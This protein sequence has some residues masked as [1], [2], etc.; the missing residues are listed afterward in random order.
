MLFLIEVIKG[1]LMFAAVC[2]GL[3]IVYLVF[4]IAREVG[5]VVKQESRKQYRAKQKQCGF[6]GTAGSYI[7]VIMPGGCFE[8]GLY[9]RVSGAYLQIY[10]GEYPG[11]IDNIEINFCPK[12]GRMLMEVEDGADGS[13]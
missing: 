5:W 8:H 1:L 4:I 11:F 2:V 10:D 13:I 12:C 7:A 9:I 3:G 6:C